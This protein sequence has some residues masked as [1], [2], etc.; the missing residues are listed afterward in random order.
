MRVI[1]LGAAG[2]LGHKMLQRLRSDY[3]IAGTIRESAPDDRLSQLLS[4]LKIYPNVEASDFLSIGQAIESWKAQ[5]VLNCIGIVKQTAAA[6][7]PITSIFINSLF[8]HRLARMT[9]EMG[10]RLIHFSTDCV[11]SGRRGNYTEEDNPDPVDLYGRTKLL[12]E[13]VG[14][15]VLTLRMSIVGRELRGHLG[16]ID[17]FLSQHGNRVN[18]Y[19]RAL[20]S[21]LTTIAMADLVSSLI[22]EHPELQGLWHV[23]GDPISKF[24]L[25]KIVNRSY[26]LEID[27]APD[28]TF[29]CDRRLD[30]D[31]FRR[32]TGWQPASW[33]E[34][35]A[36]AY[37]EELTHGSAYSG[38]PTENYL[39]TGLR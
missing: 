24:D 5:V 1:V 29:Q 15:Q 21:G 26:N 13:V 33:E 8:P 25:L 18:G 39:T 27:I 20:Y 31:R 11:F 19:T 17:W 22:R 28:E 38:R 34:M 12:G 14:H 23:S 35:I 36:N 3:E 2:M 10:V 7:D 16:L 9:A 30:S 6:S 32:R 37:L 4:G